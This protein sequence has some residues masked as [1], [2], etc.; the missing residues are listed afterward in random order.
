MELKDQGYL[1]GS[2]V[3]HGYVAIVNGFTTETKNYV[4]ENGDQVISVIYPLH[5][6]PS[7]KRIIIHRNYSS[8]NEVFDTVNA[9]NSWHLVQ[10]SRSGGLFESASEASRAINLYLAS[11]NKTN[12]E[13]GKE[14]Y[15]LDDLKAEIKKIRFECS[16]K[17]ET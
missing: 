11:M 14:T 15:V 7:G 16:M 2:Y 5:V 10:W 17:I 13:S 6:I 12:R 1:Q 8:N 3:D 9:D 4:R